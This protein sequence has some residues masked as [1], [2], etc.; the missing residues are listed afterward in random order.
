MEEGQAPSDP[1]TLIQALFTILE[2]F[3]PQFALPLKML[4]MLNAL[5]K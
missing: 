3:F 1:S 4:K 5:E 2:T